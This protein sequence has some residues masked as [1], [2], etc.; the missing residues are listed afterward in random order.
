MYSTC[1][2]SSGEEIVA[3]IAL[4]QGIVHHRHGAAEDGGYVN[5]GQ[6]GGAQGRGGLDKLGGECACG[7]ICYH[8]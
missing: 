6:R 4:G 5:R 1:D 3:V 8:R 2:F 7:L